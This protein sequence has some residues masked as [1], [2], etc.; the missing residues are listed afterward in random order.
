[1][2]NIDPDDPLFL[3]VDTSVYLYAAGERA[4][5]Q[6]HAHLHRETKKHR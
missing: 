1:M 5:D 3:I 2:L 6:V 4:L